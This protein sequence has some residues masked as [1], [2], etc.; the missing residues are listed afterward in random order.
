MK[1]GT[2]LTRAAVSRL[3]AS[4]LIVCALALHVLACPARATAPLAHTP[5]YGDAGAFGYGVA[6]ALEQQ[7]LPPED[8]PSPAPS[9]AAS[10]GSPSPGA[11]DD[12]SP[13]AEDAPAP[14][15]PLQPSAQGSSGYEGARGWT[16]VPAE[17]G[18][19]R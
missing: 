11:A 18:R 13:A 7:N 8:L 14:A 9:P 5:R 10:S 15:A 3:A 19:A 1:I 4:I 6:V 17:A 12:T 16:R 2:E